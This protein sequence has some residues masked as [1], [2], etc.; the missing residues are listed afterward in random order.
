MESMVVDINFWKNKN[1]L[2]T[3]HTGFKGSWLAILLNKLGANVS[4]FAL[5]PNKNPNLYELS[6]I[7]N[8]I[9]SH[10][11]D[12]TN[13]ESVKNLIKNIDPEIIIHMAA[14]A[15]VRESYQDPVRTYSTNI[16]GTVNL[17]EA[18]MHS[19]S[20][21]VFINITSDKCYENHETDIPYSEN[22]RMGGHDPYSC[23]KGCSELITNSFWKSYYS[24]N[25]VGL[26]SARAGNVIGGGDWSDDRLVPDILQ[27][28]QN[29]NTLNIRSPKSTRPWQHVLEP[30][31]GYLKLSEKL[32]KDPKKFSGGW[33]FGP[34][35]ENNCSVY[36]LSSLIVQSYGARVDICNQEGDHPHEASL[37]MLNNEKA[38]KY[39]QWRPKWQLK[40][41]I[42]AIVNWHRR[43]Y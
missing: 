32:Y 9:N 37:L 40:K 16:M 2:I 7:S 27:A 35:K 8:S 39:L 10:I 20:L 24:T 6:L 11:G 43:V 42:E 14:Q 29:N 26:A 12:L 1:V 38:K 5:N 28:C 25:N 36:E 17:L 22:D 4:G 18:S 21:K 15:I 23:S 33:N 31:S 30:L 41:T 13:Y 19:K 34:D 3:G